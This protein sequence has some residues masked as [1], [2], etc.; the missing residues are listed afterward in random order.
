MI[1]CFDDDDKS[2]NSDRNWIRIRPRF[3]VV[4][5]EDLRV[6]NYREHEM[7]CIKRPQLCVV[8][9]EDLWDILDNAH[10]E[11]SHAGR[12]RMYA[13]FIEHIYHIPREITALYIRLCHT[14]QEVHTENN[15]QANH[16][17]MCW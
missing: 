4:K 6:L 14:C 7:R 10:T 8:P 1:E 12:D 9:E 2:I 11:L 3:C 5:C 15:S 17:S 13:Y 16:S